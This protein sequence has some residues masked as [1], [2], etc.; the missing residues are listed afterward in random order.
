MIRRQ[1]VLGASDSRRPDPRRRHG[2]TAAQRE[3]LKARQG[4]RCLICQTR[5]SSSDPASKLTLDHDHAH[6]PGTY[7]C[8]RCYRGMLCVRCQNS[9]QFVDKHRARLLVYIGAST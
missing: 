9:M 1:R 3:A 5:E 7:G 8:P 4:F 2:F 6:C